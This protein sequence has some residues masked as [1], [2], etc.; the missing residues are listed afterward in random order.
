MQVHWNPQHGKH[1][2]SKQYEYFPPDAQLKS[3]CKEFKQTAQQLYYQH[4]NINQVHMLQMEQVFATH[5]CK[6]H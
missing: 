4:S 6:K 2:L 1:H 5:G 3:P